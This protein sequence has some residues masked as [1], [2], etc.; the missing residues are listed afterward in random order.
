MGVGRREAEAER[1][2]GLGCILSK[3]LSQAHGKLQN[4]GSHEH[5]PELERG[6]Q[7]LSIGIDHL[8][9]VS[10][11]RVRQLSSAVFSQ[12]GPDHQRL[13]SGII[14]SLW[15]MK[16]FTPKGIYQLMGSVQMSI[17]PKSMLCS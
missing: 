13:P 12:R 1:E 2:G 11:R 8:A 14:P 5:C 16:S 6:A 15:A 3:G 17:L 9:E 10:L 4:W 7:L